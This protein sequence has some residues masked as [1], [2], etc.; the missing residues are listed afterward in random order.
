[1]LA[2]CARALSR[3]VTQLR[4]KMHTIYILIIKIYIF[5]WCDAGVIVESCVCMCNLTEMKSVFY[6]DEEKNNIVLFVRA[7]VKMK[8]III[9]VVTVIA[10]YV[11][12]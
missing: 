11:D 5:K 3:T 2:V 12:V 1:M 9:T 7:R 10:L 8:R 4:A 6:R